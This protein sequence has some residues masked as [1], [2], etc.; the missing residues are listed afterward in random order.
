MK[1]AL[2]Q[3]LA[4][5]MQQRLS[6]QQVRLVRMLEMSEPEMEEE[7]RRELDDNPA[8]TEADSQDFNGGETREGHDDDFN[9]TAEEMQRADYLH[10]DDIPYYRQNI[11]NYSPDDSRYEPTAIASPETLGESLERQLSELTLSDRQMKLGRYI[12]GNIDGNG[13]LTRT[14]RELEDDLALNV[15]L[16]VDPVELREI[17][18]IIRSLDPPGVGASDLRESL[19]LQLR[20][21]RDSDPGVKTATEIVKDYFDL[22]SMRHFD[23]LGSLLRVDRDE[24]RRADEVIRSLDPKP[25]SRVG[26]SEAD[27]RLRQIT[28]DFY[29]ETDDDGHIRISM[30]SRVPSLAI[31]RSFEPESTPLVAAG[32]AASARRNQAL[33]FITRKRDEAEDFI[34][35]VRMR[36]DTL[37]RVMEA[38]V[39]VQRAFFESDDETRIRPMVLKDIAA[40]T[41]LD[42]S[43]ISR[44]TQGKYVATPS[45][46]YPLKMFFNERLNDREDA[47]SIEIMEAIRLLIAGEDV[48]APLSDDQLT[49]RLT[50]QGYNIARRTV[51]KYRERLGLPVARLRRKI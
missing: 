39:K 16:E 32:E 5:R 18:D 41:G 46:I 25:G 40:V 29:V 47:S 43:V 12:I 38:I 34:E 7:V 1:E 9:E 10:D 44:A 13:Y 2:Q 15:G 27:D 50:R 17:L 36:R 28:P 31:E 35:L 4:Q 3:T 48:S 42:I 49:E 24:L 6:P 45:G 33:Q 22:F 19:L 11:S 21:R 8:L 51:A 37:L 23:R 14:L 30:P 20:R 26:G